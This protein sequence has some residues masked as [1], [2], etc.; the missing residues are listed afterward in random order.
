MAR[1]AALLYPEPLGQPSG[2]FM[3]LVKKSVLGA[4]AKAPTTRAGAT[5]ATA[6]AG[7][8]RARPAPRTDV[9]RATTP[10]ERIDQA[11]QELAAGFGEASAAASE[12]QRALEQIATGA[13]EAAGAAQE[14]LGTITALTATF[15]DAREKADLSRRQA[16][17][18]QLAYVEV[19]TQIEGSAAAV[20][21]NSRRQL[22]SADLIAALEKAAVELG[23]VAQAVADTAEE[24]G[25]L[26]LNAAVEAARA[27]DNGR[28]FAVVADEVRVLADSSEGS[29]NEMRRLAVDAAAEIKLVAGEM[30]ASSLLAEREAA[31][32][33]TVLAQLEA[34]RAE[35]AALASG[36]H[37]VTLAAVE[38][39]AAAREAERGAE[40]VAAAA[41]Q[42]SAA[43]DEA[44]QAIRQ[45]TSALD[46]S[47]NTADSLADLAA[48]L[49]TGTGDGAAEQVAAAAEELSATVQELSGAAGEILV[50]VE[51]IGRG[52]QSQAAATAQSDAAMSQIEI[53]ATRSRDIARGAARRIEAVAASA[54]DSGRTIARLA[55]GVATALGQTRGALDRLAVLRAT[56]REIETVTDRLSL[57]AVQTGMLAV[58]G[59]TEATRLG[60]AG[61]GFGSVSMDI[62]KL[63][64]DA[65]LCGERARTIV[66]TVQDRVASLERDLDRIAA[67]AE[68][69]AGRSQRVAERLGA[70]VEELRTARA[71]SQAIETGA[72]RALESVR[73]IRKG[74]EQIAS[75]AEQASM[76]SRE[77][78]AAA[79]EQAQSAEG[80]AAIIE[81]IASLAGALQFGTA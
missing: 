60:D 16:D 30:R 38:I 13:E 68:A 43:A 10:V 58:N 25:L 66:R 79:A 63:A 37:E 45:Q 34:S 47:Q 27:G 23:T 14:S 61:R 5:Q 42:Q 50:A 29:A 59:S 8:I 36:A 71:A 40:Q 70:V 3:A 41:E 20:E 48:V 57:V 67:A 76:A 49:R 73:E 53:A 77:A 75:A 35:L 32:A 80:L 21:L 33:R 11:T 28:G 78:A 15:R 22:A 17:A 9:R 46:Q 2:G 65:A 24:T 72:D 19:G 56:S 44:Q 69:E 4:R 55:T 7:P 51:Q 62:R 64:R 6:D 31:A 74:T 12:L 18:V 81:E 52:A 1:A 26:A 39:E 54:G